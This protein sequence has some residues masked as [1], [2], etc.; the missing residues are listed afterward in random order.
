MTAPDLEA[1]GEALMTDLTAA[2]GTLTADKAAAFFPGLPVDDQIVQNGVVNTLQLAQW[3]AT[4]DTPLLLRPG[5]AETTVPPGGASATAIYSAIVNGARAVD[6][7]GAAGQQLTQRIF[8]DK[9]LLDQVALEEPLGSEPPD[10]PLP[11][12]PSWQTASTGQTQA[13]PDPYQVNASV[14]VRSV[15]N[16]VS[17]ADDPVVIWS[18]AVGDAVQAGQPLGEV[19]TAKVT[20]E[21]L[22]PV[23]GFLLQK[24]VPDGTVVKAD[25]VIGIV[26]P[27]PPAPEVTVDY[28]YALVSLTRRVA[29]TPWWDD[30]LLS[31]TTWF[32]PGRAAGGLLPAPAAG[33]ANAL[34]YALLVV[35]NVVVNSPGLTP[36]DAASVGP[37][38]VSPTDGP[39]G[40]A[41]TL[42]WTGMQAI[43]VVA[44]VLPP[45]P[46]KSD[47]TLPPT[48]P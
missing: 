48:T 27:K 16:G 33:T 21:F 13:Q 10:W 46:P 47:P 6:A 23:T 26:G 42:S 4:F 14:W 3:L 43:G 15:G 18:K 29:G 44:N 35:R 7:T 9:T 2:F 45:L 39:A 41:G 8:A 17:A 28:Q 30:V 25:E 24:F 19:E 36:A 40:S 12:A 32:I 34:P 1:A 22:S 11:N 38:R 5:Q 20:T 37:V 31:D